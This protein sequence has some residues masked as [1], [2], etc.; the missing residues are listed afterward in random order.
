MAFFSSFFT[1]S[2][3][4][5]RVPEHDSA[6]TARERLQI[7]VAHQRSKRL[8]ES[9]FVNLHRELLE[10]VRRHVQIEDDAVSI[11]ISKENDVDILELNIIL[12]EQS[13]PP[14]QLIQEGRQPP[15]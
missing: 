7:V 3:K 14:N 1:S 12:P 6:T 8:G 15:P 5:A 11:Q 9:A 10:V 2:A 13:F 4:T